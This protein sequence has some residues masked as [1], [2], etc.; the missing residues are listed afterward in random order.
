MLGLH[1]NQEVVEMDHHGMS[2]QRRKHGQ[3]GGVR[4]VELTQPQRICCG[5]KG[6]KHP[7]LLHV[8]NGRPYGIRILQSPLTRVSI[9]IYCFVPLFY[10]CH[11]VVDELVSPCSKISVIF[12]CKFPHFAFVSVLVVCV[13]DVKQRQAPL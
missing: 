5:W 4:G 3:S 6:L 13:G 2:F 8:G 11:P 9:V 12:A 7:K 10:T 1:Q